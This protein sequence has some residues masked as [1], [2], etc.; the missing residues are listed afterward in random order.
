MKPILLA[1]IFLHS[2]IPCHSQEKETKG[3]SS[4]DLELTISDV[5]KTKTT[6]EIVITLKNTG[7]KSILTVSPKISDNFK[8]SYFLGFDDNGKTLQIRRHFFS[9]PNSVLDAPEPCYALNIIEAGKGISEKFVLGYPLAVNSYLLGL[10]TDISKYD[11]YNAQIGVLPFDDAIYKIQNRRPFGQC[12]EPQDRI[13][14]G[15]YTGK[16]LIEIQK[17]LSVDSK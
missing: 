7:S 10:E 13:E 3:F 1:L 16:T 9:Y 15:I 11:K 2:F 8:T 12:V 14:S 6:L 17:I 5:K 4:N